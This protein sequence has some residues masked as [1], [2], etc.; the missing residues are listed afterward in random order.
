MFQP[1]FENTLLIASHNRGKIKEISTLLSPF[2]IKVIS[3]ADMKLS[4]PEETGTT[5]EENALLKAEQGYAQT[6]VATLADDSGLCIEALNGDPGIHTG[7]WAEACGGYPKAFAE[8]ERRLQGAA[9]LKASFFC[10]LALVTA[11]QQHHFFIGRCDGELVFPPSGEK[12]F[13]YDPI[14]KPEGSKIVFAQM[15]PAQKKNYSHRGQ[16]LKKFVH[17]CFKTSSI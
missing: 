17:R 2:N 3:A 7:R 1:P 9:S 12:G 15:D 10:V 4:D 5:F 14:F 16:A 6:G 11:P 13:G 8:L